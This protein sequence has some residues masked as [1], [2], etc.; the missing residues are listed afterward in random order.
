MII[1]THCHLDKPRYKRQMKKILQD[2]QENDV[3]GVLIP[4]TQK[5]TL[6]DAQV[7]AQSYVGI[8]YSVGFHP[9]YAEKFEMET[10]EAYVE[11]ERCIAIGEFGLDY[12]RLSK[13][14]EVRRPVIDEQK[15]VLKIHLDFAVKHQKPVLIHLRDKHVS[16][17]GEKTAYDDFLEIL[18]PYLGKLV[19][20]VIHAINFDRADYLA[21]AEHGFYFGIGGQLTYERFEALKTFVKKARLSSL[22]LETDAPW[23]TPQARKKPMKE[24]ANKPSYIVDVLAEL[25]TVL[26]IEEEALSKQLVQNTLALFPQFQESVT[27]KGYSTGEVRSIALLGAEVIRQVASEIEEIESEETQT[28]IDDLLLTCIDS[29][30]MGIASPQISVS[31][32]LFIM[33]SKPNKRYPSAPKMKPKAIINPKIIAYGDEVEKDWEGCL[34]LP[35]VRALVPRSTQIEVSYFTRDGKAVNEVLDGFLARVF[36]HEFDHLD[37]K[38]FIDRVESALDVVMEKEYMRMIYSNN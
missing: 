12:G 23:L 27:S 21:L 24:V 16:V 4:S 19:G 18:E 7:L 35:N 38:V 20:G 31:K 17:Y 22:L 8:F 37:G 5:N 29:Q 30:G 1:D 9:K 11:D 13:E 2:A 26:N 15:R 6:D 10:L 3:L 14:E 36:Q 34:S 32:R 28:L 25:S 33:A